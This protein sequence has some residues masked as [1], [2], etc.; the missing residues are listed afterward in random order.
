MNNKIKNIIIIIN[1]SFLIIA[2]ICT[3]MFNI[4]NSIIIVF[5][6]FI[7]IT[8][9]SYRTYF[10]YNNYENEK[11]TQYRNKTP[12]IIIACLTYLIE[13]IITIFLQRYDSNFIS[14]IIPCLIIQDLVV[15]TTFNISF[16]STIFIYII[17]STLFYFKFI[18][19][20]SLMVISMIIILTI[21]ITLFV[22]F[23]L[24][25]YLIKQ[26][27]IIEESLRNITIKNLEKDI[28]YLNLKEAYRKIEEVTKLRERNKIAAQI[29]DTVGHTLTTVLVELEASKRLM[30][31]DIE[32]S[33]EKLS[34]A[35][36]QVRKG[37]KEIRSSVRIIEKGEE[38]LDFMSSIEA[39]IQDTIKHSEVIINKE[40]QEGIYIP[41][42]VE[43]VLFFSLMEGLS[44]GIRHGKATVFIFKLR[45]DLN[46][47]SFSLEDNG[48]GSSL[49]SQGFGLRAMASRVEDINGN[50][51]FSSNPLEGFKLEITIP[52]K[53][54][55]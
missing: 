46:R 6:Y 40:I 4:E 54:L 31:K 27:K 10:V 8:S 25:N 32:K 48:K 29:H 19:N 17:S 34:L 11:G 44:N 28:L 5:F 14:F 20:N 55:N 38:L 1:Y 13:I 52:I 24:I 16:L 26:N 47:I 51:V 36:E 33:K 21:Y 39:L 23:Y 30:V 3:S 37:L 15:N 49:I 2:M 18:S 7:V 45:Y 41:K 9:Y 43:E 50:L 12:L 35:Q 22:V 53:K 42:E